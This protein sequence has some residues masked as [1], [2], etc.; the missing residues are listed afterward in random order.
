M[1]SR[2]SETSGGIL[3]RFLDSLRSLGMTTGHYSYLNASIGCKSDA[4]FAGYQP[5]IIPMTP[6]TKK[7]KIIAGKEIVKS[8]LII[9]AI[10]Y[11]V[12]TPSKEPMIPPL[13]VKITASVKNWLI[14]IFFLAPKAFLKPISRVRSVTVTNIIF[15]IPIPPTKREMAAIPDKRERYLL[16]MKQY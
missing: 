10:K 3:K 14:I 6:E 4:F 13:K 15:M 9:L 7:A 11:E 2:P 8:T 16:P 12:T 5:K 1:S